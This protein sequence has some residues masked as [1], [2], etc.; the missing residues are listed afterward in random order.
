MEEEIGSILE[1]NAGDCL[2]LEGGLITSCSVRLSRT[3]PVSTD[4]RFTMK[5]NKQNT[6][7][8]IPKMLNLYKKDTFCHVS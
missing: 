5:T 7:A 1:E 4:K 8:Y 2:E 3:Q 6:S